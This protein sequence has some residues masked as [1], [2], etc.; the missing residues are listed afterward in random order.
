MEKIS[1]EDFL[2]SCDKTSVIDVRSPGEFAH[3]HIPGAVNIPLFSNIERAVVGTTY[4][5]EGKK[6]AVYRG[7]EIVGEKMRK[8]AEAADRYSRGG[9]VHLYCWRGGM[10]SGSVAW[11]LE[12]CG[13]TP[14]LLD[15]GYKAFRN[16]VIEINSRSY[17]F[18]VLSGKTGS[19]K[20]KILR[21]IE[22]MGG[23]VLD[24]EGIARHKGSAFGHLGEKTQ[25]S[26]E[27]FENIIAMRLR[28]FSEKRI[29]VEDESRNIGYCTIPAKIW[30]NMRGAKVFLLD[31]T[32]D[33]RLSNIME[34]Y[35]CFSSA[36]LEYGIRKI[37]ERLGS[38]RSAEAI[39]DV[40]AGNF[41]AAAKISL[42]YYDKAYLHGLGRRDQEKIQ[43]V[44][45]NDCGTD[46]DMIASRLLSLM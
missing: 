16:Y 7:L 30:E 20:T 2:S 41:E 9:K 46:V 18:A 37:S 24:L 34:D 15:G 23:Q 29:W 1:V 3:A 11:L 38:Q 8:I 32:F 14:V 27:Q 5:K 17:E 19:G 6:K 21:K 35:G 13:M 22:S 45:V 12:L 39:A 4:K 31:V 36:Q 25:P 44:D 42:E 26:N 33:A 28:D 10:R 43:I 40:R